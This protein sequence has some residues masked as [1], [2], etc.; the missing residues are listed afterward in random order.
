[1]IRYSYKSIIYY[2]IYFFQNLS[3]MHTNKK[4][5]VCNLLLYFIQYQAK[6]L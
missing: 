5:S 2:L 6:Q 3:A 1:M 4:G